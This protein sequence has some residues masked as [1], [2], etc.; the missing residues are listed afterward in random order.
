MLGAHRGG[1]GKPKAFV[2][3]THR[4]NVEAAAALSKQLRDVAADVPAV[5]DA[6][7]CVAIAASA[8][9]MLTVLDRLIVEAQADLQAL[10]RVREIMARGASSSVDSTGPSAT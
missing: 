4:R 6:A 8:Q 3:D 9:P 7:P 10:E 5:V 1:A 2:S